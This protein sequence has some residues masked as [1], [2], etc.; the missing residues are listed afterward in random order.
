MSS[1]SLLQAK[2]ETK[3]T[4]EPVKEASVPVTSIKAA[5][6]VEKDS[7]TKDAGPRQAGARRSTERTRGTRGN[8]TDKS[9]K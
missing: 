8:T 2:I 4:P 9:E 1:F 5:G 7:L 3:A 6:T